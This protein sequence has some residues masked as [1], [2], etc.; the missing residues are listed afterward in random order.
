MHKLTRGLVVATFLH[1]SALCWAWD[2]ESGVHPAVLL[3]QIP[4][5][6]SI[7]RVDASLANGA[8]TLTYSL[9]QSGAMPRPFT[10]SRFTPA[11]G[12][13]G[14]AAN[15]PD[16]HMPETVMALNGTLIHPQDQ[17]SAWFE[18]TN[19]SALL[20]KAKIEALLVAETESALIDPGR[21]A[22]GRIRKLF[23]SPQKSASLAYPLWFVTH[24]RTWRVPPFTGTSALMSVRYNA[25]PATHQI[26]VSS[27]AFDAQLLSHCA[28]PSQVRALIRGMTHQPP[29]TALLAVLS[30]P[31]RVANMAPADATLR[32]QGG[33]SAPL[34]MTLVGSYACAGDGSAADT[35]HLIRG[36]KLS[37]PDETSVL[38]IYTAN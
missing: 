17:T 37:A 27:R 4:T 10:L 6:L 12:W 33:T 16:K 18:G 35:S 14:V 20:R 23:S 2:D 22:D 5:S 21:L 24:Q 8:V 11:F 13:E 25:R 19:I 29:E 1:T 31:L 32:I 9:T 26:D 3:G 36:V 15:Y 38:S 28:D 30:V 34:G 7:S